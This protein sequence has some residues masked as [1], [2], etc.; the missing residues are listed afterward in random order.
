LIKAVTVEIKLN[1][2]PH[3]V[4]VIGVTGDSGTI[5]YTED[6][7]PNDFESHFDEM[8][9]RAVSAIKRRVKAL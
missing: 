7:S 6:F 3:P 8:I 9:E 4:L 5:Y 1:D 2:S